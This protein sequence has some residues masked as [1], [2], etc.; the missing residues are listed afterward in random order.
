M[1]ALPRWLDRPFLLLT[2]TAFIWG[3][4]AVAGRVADGHVSPMWIT[5]GRWAIAVAVV[6]WIG[7][8]AIRA[9]WP[10]IR[11]N[12]RYLAAMGATGFT[13]FNFLLY[14]AAKY[15]SAVN[16]ALLQSAMPLFIFA[17]GYALFRTPVRA[18]QVAGFVLTAAGVWVT[19]T[20]G[21]VL[22]PFRGE[23]SGVNVGDAIMLLAALAYAAYS[24]GLKAKPA[25]QPLS[26]LFAIV[27]AALVTATFGLGAEI[28]SGTSQAPHD[29]EG[30][31][32]IGYAGI[33][34]A[35][36]AQAFFIRGV[37]AVGANTAGLFINLVPVFAAI[38]SVALLGEALAAFH[39][40]AFVL[41]VG[42]VWL[43][44]RAGN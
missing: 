36:V 5:F 1:L 30:W 19:A 18:V 10:A 20:Y 16:V 39:A 34:A 14:T 22:A 41:V 43:A 35:I 26:F 15:T 3:G 2:L 24:V 21:D 12:W 31:L 6:G 23:G 38:L 37:D 8:G 11:A 13:F 27:L 40:V 7:R 33:F 28:A 9:D 29:L 42:G 44:G 17:L 32:V 4:N 25:M